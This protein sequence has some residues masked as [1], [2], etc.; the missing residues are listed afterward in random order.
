MTLAFHFPL[1]ALGF[2]L[3]NLR[4]SCLSVLLRSYYMSYFSSLCDILT[5]IALNAHMMPIIVIDNSLIGLALIIAPYSIAI[6]HI[7]ITIDKMN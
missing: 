5:K 1:I 7:A 2:A 4:A 6:V 3:L